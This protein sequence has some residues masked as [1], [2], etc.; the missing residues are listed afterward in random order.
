MD[1]V[2]FLESIVPFCSED[3]VLDL[4]GRKVGITDFSIGRVYYVFKL[5]S[6]RTTAFNRA[7]L[8]EFQSPVRRVA[9]VRE[10]AGPV[11]IIHN[12]SIPT[13][14]S[15]ELL[16]NTGIPKDEIK[17]I[18]KRRGTISLVWLC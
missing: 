3:D 8:I 12:Q 10:L 16:D 18:K 4:R 2:S 1:I 15:D 13:P 5:R 14:G 9:L 17:S 11:K 6:T 7:F